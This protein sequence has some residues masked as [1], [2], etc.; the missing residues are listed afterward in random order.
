MVTT[1]PEQCAE[2]MTSASIHDSGQAVYSGREQRGM[3]FRRANHFLAHDAKGR[4]IGTFGNAIDARN[5]ILES[6][7]ARKI[8]AIAAEAT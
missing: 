3:I 2:V 8:G 5:A 4:K 7:P 1:N 6:G